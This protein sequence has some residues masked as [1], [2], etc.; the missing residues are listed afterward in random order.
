MNTLSAIE[1]NEVQAIIR[2]KKNNN[3][4]QDYLLSFMYSDDYSEEKIIQANELL[5]KELS[6]DCLDII[7][8]GA[9]YY[10]RSI[11]ESFTEKTA[12]LI[13]AQQTDT[14]RE[15]LVS[16]IDQYT[17]QKVV[18]QNLQSYYNDLFQESCDIDRQIA[19]LQQRRANLSIQMS[20][21]EKEFKASVFDERDLK[22]KCD[23]LQERIEEVHFNPQ[24]QIPSTIRFTLPDI[25]DDS[26]SDSEKSEAQSEDD[27]D[28]DGEVYFQL[29]ELSLK[30]AVTDEQIVDC[31]RHSFGS[32]DNTFFVNNTLSVFTS[33]ISVLKDNDMSRVTKIINDSLYRGSSHPQFSQNDLTLITMQYPQLDFLNRLTGQSVSV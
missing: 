9:I 23:M 8:G 6:L 3:V 19:M 11:R 32:K 31:I 1:I 13:L 16:T 18:T 27:N 2:N 7:F 29:L 22:E 10:E 14:H 25:E 26:D 15:E 5:Y 12:E 20:K 30:E 24:P 4:S 17:Q 21:V 33:I 28:E